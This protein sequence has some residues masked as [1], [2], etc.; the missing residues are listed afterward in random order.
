MSA[1]THCEFTRC[2]KCGHDCGCAPKPS[3]QG[4]LDNSPRWDTATQ[5]WQDHAP[6]NGYKP[7]ALDLLELP[8]MDHAGALRRMAHWVNRGIVLETPIHKYDEPR[9]NKRTEYA[10]NTELRGTGYKID[11]IL[12]NGELALVKI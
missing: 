7:S 2:P 4:S 11:P 5:E 1:C 12:R 9:I 8:P 10:M 6:E 3:S